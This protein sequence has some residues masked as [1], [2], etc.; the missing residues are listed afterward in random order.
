MTNREQKGLDTG[1]AWN[2]FVFRWSEDGKQAK[3]EETDLCSGYPLT[4]ED[5]EIMNGKKPEEYVPEGM[6]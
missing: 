2:D 6:E 4:R 1:K 5:W 3:K